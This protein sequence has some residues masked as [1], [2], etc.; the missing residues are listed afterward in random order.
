MD[1]VTTH[2]GLGDYT[3]SYTAQF[4]KMLKCKFTEL[5]SAV[6]NIPKLA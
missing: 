1:D 5:Q 3:Q 2:E 4:Q 6:A